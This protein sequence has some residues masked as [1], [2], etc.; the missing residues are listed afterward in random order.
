MSLNRETS[1]G[2]LLRGSGDHTLPDASLSGSNS[3]SQISLNSPSPMKVRVPAIRAEITEAIATPVDENRDIAVDLVND[4][5]GLTF[6][7][8]GTPVPNSRQ[9]Y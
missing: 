4:R 9:S 6:F 8:A 3:N 7:T 1:Y 2:Q 5:M